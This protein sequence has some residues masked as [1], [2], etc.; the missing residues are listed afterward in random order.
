MK[1][2]ELFYISFNFSAAGKVTKV[3]VRRKNDPRGKS[4]KKN[5]REQRVFGNFKIF[6]EFSGVLGSF[7]ILE[8]F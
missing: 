7:G 5:V 6:E 8:S 4:L 2:N 1:K 3:I